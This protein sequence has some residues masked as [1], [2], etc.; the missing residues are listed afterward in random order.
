MSQNTYIPDEKPGSL[1]NLSDIKILIC[2]LLNEIDQ[3]LTKEQLNSVFQISEMV[4]YFNYCQAVFELQK[5]GHLLELGKNSQ[6]SVLSLTPLGVETAIELCDV[7][8]PTIIQRALR[9]TQKVLKEEKYQQGKQIHISQTEDG[10]LVRL[11]I[12]EVGSDLLDICLFAP[13]LAQAKRIS[14]EF[15]YKTIDIYRGMIAILYNDSEHLAQVVKDIENMSPQAAFH[16][17]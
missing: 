9:T 8:P 12:L 1:S 17:Q 7:L 6:K 4:N 2:Y 15:Q 13:N 11:Q 5:S 16:T 10:Y 14:N 3:D